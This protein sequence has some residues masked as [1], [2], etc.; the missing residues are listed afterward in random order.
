MVLSVAEKTQRYGASEGSGVCRCVHVHAL[1][2]CVN[3]FLTADRK[4]FMVS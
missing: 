3:L 4:G 2:V 1:F